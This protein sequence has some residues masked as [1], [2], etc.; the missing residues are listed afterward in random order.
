MLHKTKVVD[1]P[2]LPFDVINLRGKNTGG[3]KPP[4]LPPRKLCLRSFDRSSTAYFRQTRRVLHIGEHVRIKAF[5][6]QSANGNKF[7]FHRTHQCLTKK[8]IESIGE[9]L[10]RTIE[11]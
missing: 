8:Y 11:H 4:H 9:G 3:Q 10:Y 7:T 6:S 2:S 5:T 1:N